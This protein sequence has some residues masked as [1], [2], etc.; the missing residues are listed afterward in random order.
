LSS[1]CLVKV[2][3]PTGVECYSMF[4][5]PVDG[6]QSLPRLAAVPSLSR[7]LSQGSMENSTVTVSLNN[8][9]DYFTEKLNTED[10]YIISKRLEIYELGVQIFS[11]AVCSY[12]E[13]DTNR[14]TIKADVFQ[15]LKDNAN[16]A[17]TKDEFPNCPENNE[18]K[19]GNIILGTADID[20]GMFTAYRIDDGKY[21]AAYHP[22]S[23]L[24]AATDKDGNI[25]S[26]N[27]TLSIDQTTGNSIIN[28]ST[29]DDYICF[30]ALG[31]LDEA[32]TLIDNPAHMLDYALQLS[33][34]FEIENLSEVA[35]VYESRGY[36]GN[37]LFVKDN[38]TF[39]ELLDRFGESFNC[40]PVFSRT[41]KINLNLI[42]WAN[43][44]PAIS[45]TGV[46]I[47]DFTYRRDTSFL[48]KYYTRKFQPIPAKDEFKLTPVTVSGTNYNSQSTE[49]LQYFIRQAA[50]SWDVAMREIYLL[51][52]PLFI[53]EFSI[54][55]NLAINLDLGSI[56]G[57]EHNDCPQKGKRLVQIRRIKNDSFYKLEALDL[58]VMQKSTFILKTAGSSDVTRI[59]SSGDPRNVSV[60]FNE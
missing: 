1:D 7:A 16:R 2:S 26:G 50:T 52:H 51:K 5:M 36:A 46:H 10:M 25:I 34:D 31:P 43:E 8:H 4:S 28:H 42:R 49:L 15:K 37:F 53:Y 21:L 41:G 58:S 17:I 32:D 44:T 13:R 11:G 60:W 54:H 3:W 45:I 12:P 30:S 19:Y 55:R 20:A 35:A 27:C 9:D 48:Y 14:L 47:K 59:Y 22:L 57:I 39:A 33:S 6:G 38:T 40:K 56:I 24:L 23:E 29:N 18:G